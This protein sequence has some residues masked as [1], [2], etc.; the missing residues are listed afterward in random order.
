M[1]FIHQKY[2]PMMTKEN[3][4][5]KEDSPLRSGSLR[6][7]TKNKQDVKP[8]QGKG[9][10]KLIEKVNDMKVKELTKKRKINSNSKISFN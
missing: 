9:L 1:L 2:K 8:I 10:N 4:S 7:E 6:Q 3:V 5:I